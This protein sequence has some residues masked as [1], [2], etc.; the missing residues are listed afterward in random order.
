LVLLEEVADRSHGVITK[1]EHNEILGRIKSLANILHAIDPHVS[2]E[3]ARGTIHADLRDRCEHTGLLQFLSS[4]QHP[5][6]LAY[7]YTTEQ[8]AYAKIRSN[9]KKP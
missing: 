5:K 9:F 1:K 6:A 4:R 2:V 7:L 3:S 8:E